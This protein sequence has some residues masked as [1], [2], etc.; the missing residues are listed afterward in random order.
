MH[1]DSERW[2]LQRKSAKCTQKKDTRIQVTTTEASRKKRKKKRVTTTTKGVNAKENPENKRRALL[3][4][5][6]N[7]KVHKHR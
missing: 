6:Q 4:T 5:T 7:H 3:M 1:H 2:F